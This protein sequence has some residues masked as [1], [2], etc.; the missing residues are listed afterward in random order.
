MSTKS[1]FR[2]CWPRFNVYRPADRR[3]SVALNRYPGD[4]IGVAV[5]LGGWCWGVRWKR[6]RR[7]GES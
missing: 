4:V 6:T 5:V 1:N 2:W 3:P 7:V